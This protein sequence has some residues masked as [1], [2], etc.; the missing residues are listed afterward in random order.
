MSWVR[1]GSCPPERCQGRCCEHIGVWFNNVTPQAYRFVKQMRARGLDVKGRDGDYL[2]DLPQRCQ[3][4]TSGGLCA[5]HPD[6]KPTPSLPK[7]PDFC[8]EWP[9]EPSQLINDP[10]CGYSFTWV[11]DDLAIGVT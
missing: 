2:I 8:A 10:Q 3:H 5:L 9:A 6:M 7:R 11:E 1:E 4:L